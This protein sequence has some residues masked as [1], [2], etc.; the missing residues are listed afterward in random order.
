MTNSL[1]TPQ[2]QSVLSRL[3]DAAA[4][5]DDHVPA[6]PPG[7]NPS[8]A[9]RSQALQDVYIPIS[10]EAGKLLYAAVTVLPGDARQT[11]A[12]L[13]GPIGLVLLDGWK[14]LCLPVLRL[15]E[16]KLTPGALVTAD[17][18]DGVEISSWTR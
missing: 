2:V 14:D 8:A 9:E 6:R 5:D 10:A 12:G 16:P 7:W 17:D 13:P 4:H 1:A 15:L 11:L 3:F 18:N